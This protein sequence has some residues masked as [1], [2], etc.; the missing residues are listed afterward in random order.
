VLSLEVC[1]TS[2]DFV[3]ER[4]KVD[5]QEE[6]RKLYRRTGEWL[7]GMLTF[8]ADKSDDFLNAIDDALA[9]EDLLIH[10]CYIDRI[11]HCWR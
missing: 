7:S 3:A 1:T 2:V 10:Q 9:L 11:F 6:G 8:V 5:E 4:K